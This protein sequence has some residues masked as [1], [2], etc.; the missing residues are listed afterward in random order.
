MS[1]GRRLLH[2]LQQR[3]DAGG[4]ECISRINDRHPRALVMT[5]QRQLLAQ[6]ADYRH[7]D[8]LLA[9]FR[10]HPDQVRV[11]ATLALDAGIAATAGPPVFPRLGA[12]QA[13]GQRG[14]EGTLA[15]PGRATEQQ[16]V[17]QA[18]GLHRGLHPR[19]DSLMPRQDLQRR[20]HS[21]CSKV[22]TNVAL[23]CFSGCAASI[24]A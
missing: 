14:S 22:C 1:M 4:V 18:L 11:A 8:L 16:S 15:H 6:R 12:Q 2:H 20:A 24:T 9:L 13:G 3:V 21:L 5:A 10:L 7:A 19:P 23:T 17:A